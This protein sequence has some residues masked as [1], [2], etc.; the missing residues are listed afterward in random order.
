MWDI[1]HV[2]YCA[3]TVNSYV[4]FCTVG[5]RNWVVGSYNARKNAPKYAVGLP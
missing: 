3:K 5:N 4:V 2:Q 1:S